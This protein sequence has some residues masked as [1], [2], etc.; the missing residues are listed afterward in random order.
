MY[1]MTACDSRIMTLNAQQVAVFNDF[2]AGNSIFITGPAGCGK[3]YLIEHIKNYCNETGITVGVT[4]LTGAAAC[5]I[6]GQ[7][8]HSWGGLGLAQYP[9]DKLVSNICS[10]PPFFQRWRKTSVL[11]IDEISMMSGELFNKI[12]LVAQQVRARKGVFFGGIQVVFSGDFA[13]L[14]P[15]GTDLKLVFETT[16]WNESIA[17]HTHYLSVILR[18][19]D[20]VFQQ[21]LCE[22]RLGIVTDECKKRLTERIITDDSEAD[23]EI[24]GTGQKIRATILYP[25]KA[26]VEM[27]NLT[28]LDKLKSSGAETRE[29]IATDSLYARGSKV[30]NGVSEADRVVLDKACPA[31]RKLELPIGAQVML[32]KNLD[33]ER[34]LVNG[35][36]GVVIEYSNNHP[37]VVFDCGVKTTITQATFER[38]KGKN[39]LSRQQY[40]LIL[41]W[42]ITIH[43]CQGATITNVITDLSKVFCN[44]QTYVTLSRVNSLEGLFLIGINFKG[45]K[46][47]PKVRKYYLDLSQRGRDTFSV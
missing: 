33:F 26:D 41:A 19:T 20:P 5:I 6:G 35:S 28:E 31:P 39:T 1:K 37:V 32:T 36:R 11:I 38:E 9:V 30:S 4:A 45:I 13:Q 18:Q 12:N 23:I 29:Y 17:P 43:K 14:E 16:I 47:N 22:V 10:K 8:I 7:T 2:V 27:I 25:H 42:A 3:S 46:C 44:A 34:K 24:E 21:L 40:P 15:I